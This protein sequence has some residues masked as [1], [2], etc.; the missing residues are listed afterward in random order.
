MHLVNR[1]TY[2]EITWLLQISLHQK[3]LWCAHDSKI[4][5][6]KNRTEE[7]ET[8]YTKQRNYCVTL[9]RKAKVEYYSN[10]N[11]KDVTDNKMFWKTV[12]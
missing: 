12:K 1:T 4:G 3:K 5:F 9:L 8:K 11:E 2:K 6:L 7:N 10:P